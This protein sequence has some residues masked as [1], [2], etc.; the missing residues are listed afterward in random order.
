M[1]YLQLLTI[2]YR[3]LHKVHAFVEAQQDKSKLRK[4]FRRG[5]MN[6]LLN[7]CHAGLQ[8]AIDAFKVKTLLFSLSVLTNG[9]RFSKETP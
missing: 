9:T 6:T 8:E 7:N 3:T 4:L 1:Y 2:F 5:E